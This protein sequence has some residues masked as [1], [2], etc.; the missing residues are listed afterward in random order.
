MFWFKARSISR[1]RLSAVVIA[2][3]L[4]PFLLSSGALAQSNPNALPSSQG[5]FWDRP[6]PPPETGTP[7]D[8]IGDPIGQN[9]ATQ[10]EGDHL[11][12]GWDPAGGTD[13]DLEEKREMIA[14]IVFDFFKLGIPV[15]ATI[16]KFT[17]TALENPGAVQTNNEAAAATQGILACEWIEF[18]A[19]SAGTALSEA[20]PD[21]TNGGECA[22]SSVAGKKS[23][24]PVKFGLH[25][26]TF[27]LTQIMDQMWSRGDNTAISL[28]PDVASASPS[29]TPWSTAF[30][31]GSYREPDDPLD[32]ASP[33]TAQPGIFASVSWVAPT[34]I[35]DDFGGFDSFDTTETFGGDDFGDTGGDIVDTGGEAAPPEQPTDDL[36]PVAGIFDTSKSL[37]DIPIGAWLGGLIGVLALSFAGVALQG[38]PATAGRRTGAVDAMMRGSTDAS[39]DPDGG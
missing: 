34:P 18:F 12:V 37:W 29:A 15:G 38:A 19:G 39:P 32:P 8:L 23:A 21:G 20:P 24:A 10:F 36:T 13:G 26:W 22:S 25:A 11:Y 16:T 31:A 7:V 9:V 28:E 4:F 17:L 3:A 6:A 33:S 27:E 5:W 1:R 30:R 2:V 14:G 35:G